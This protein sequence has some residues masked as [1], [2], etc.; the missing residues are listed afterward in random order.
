MITS[1]GDDLSSQV[2][3]MEMWFEQVGASIPGQTSV[4]LF[5]PLR[6]IST[7]DLLTCGGWSSRKQQ[8]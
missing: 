5:H 8:D 1:D 4:C 2:R 7:C 3:V 6:L